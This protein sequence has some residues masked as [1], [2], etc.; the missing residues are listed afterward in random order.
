MVAILIV[1]GYDESREVLVRHLRDAGYDAAG[2]ADE[3]EAREWI[4]AR[5]VDVIVLDLP[6][7]ELGG[8]AEALRRAA[9][10]SVLVAL[11]DPRDGR[12]R[13]DARARGVDFFVLRPC[14][15]RALEA[16]V[17]RVLTR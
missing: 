15:P 7:A 4:A 16:H 13:A 17:R 8:A 2:V 12:A 9:R 14:T 10:A 6:I 5:P 3:D 1:D 11:I